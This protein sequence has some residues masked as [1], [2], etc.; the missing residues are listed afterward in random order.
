MNKLKAI[1]IIIKAKQYFVLSEKSMSGC[2]IENDNTI[3]VHKFIDAFKAMQ[4]KSKEIII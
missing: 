2:Y 1:W 4:N 3:F